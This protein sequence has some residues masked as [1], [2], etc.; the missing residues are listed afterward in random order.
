VPEAEIPKGPAETEVAVRLMHRN[1]KRSIM[2]IR[3]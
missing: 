1:A 3:E 2:G